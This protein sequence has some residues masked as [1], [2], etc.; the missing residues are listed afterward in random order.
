MAFLDFIIEL[1]KF[2]GFSG[3]LFIISITIFV[4]VYAVHKDTEEIK[5]QIK[6]KINE[7]KH[8]EN[9]IEWAKNSHDKTLNEIKKEMKKMEETEARLDNYHLLVMGDVRPESLQTLIHVK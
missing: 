8:K 1:A 3:L 2:V 5:K 4:Y 6:L 7:L 9:Q